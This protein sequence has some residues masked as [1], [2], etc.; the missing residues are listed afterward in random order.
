M[1]KH[2]KWHKPVPRFER[3]S[4]TLSSKEPI[5]W[6]KRYQQVFDDH[7]TVVQESDQFP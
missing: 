1:T 7:S 4:G 2:L 5:L 3:A 6:P